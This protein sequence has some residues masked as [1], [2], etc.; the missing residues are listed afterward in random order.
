M[1]QTIFLLA[2]LFSATC[3]AQNN[4]KFNLDF[5]MYKDSED[6]SEG[7]IKWGSYT[8]SIDED[9]IHSGSKSAKISS[10]D[11]G[12]DF[13]SI[14][15]KIPAKYQ[16]EVI[17][18]EGYMKTKDVADGFAG[19]LMRI[20]GDG[21]SLAF[22]N[23]ES[24]EIKGTKDWKK[25]SIILPF[26]DEA[27]N[28]FVAGILVGKGEAWFDDFVLSIDGQDVQTLKEVKPELVKAQLDKEFDNGSLIDLP[29]LNPQL[30]NDLELLGKVW[31]FLKYHHPEI[32]AGNYNWDYEL[33]RLLPDYLKANDIKSRDQI[34]I[35]WIDQFG[36]IK[37]CDGCKEVDENAILKTD[38]SWFDDQGSLLRNKLQEVYAGRNT[39]K[40]YYIRMTP[41]VGNPVFQNEQDYAS[42]SYPDD[43][44]RLLTV[45]RYWNMIQYYFPNKHL[46]DKDWNTILKEYIPLFVEAK[47]ELAYERAAVQIIGEVAD[48]HANLWGGG[49]KIRE[50]RGDHYPAVHLRFIE[51]QLTVVDY[52]NPEL[53]EK[54]GLE[55]GDVITSV[56]GKSVVDLIDEKTPFYP[57]SNIPSR[58]RNLAPDLLRSTKN[59]I[60]IKFIRDDQ[61]LVKSIPLYLREDL[62]MYRWYPKK[63]GKCYKMLDD[64]IGY[65]TL[66]NIKNGDVAAIIK[67]FKDTKGIVIDIRNYPSTFVPF[68]LGSFFLSTAT[69]FAKFTEGSISNPGEFVM[70]PGSIISPAE[71]VYSGKLVILVNEL[72][73]SQA[74]YTAMAFRAGD[75]TTVIGSTTAGAD[76]NIS[77]ILLPGGLRTIISGIGVY[78]PNGGETQRIGIVPDIEVKPTLKGIKEGRDE[79]LERAQ[80]FI[81]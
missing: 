77:K 72:T 64:N 38:L 43:G 20:D 30:V 22:D 52:Y 35:N 65:V 49:D 17:T 6:L 47:D 33:F 10:D 81:K 36:I 4:P 24:Q 32:A 40:H 18:L 56:E 27:E 26:P 69:P 66:Q 60:E 61:E 75:N 41:N 9:V 54:I 7:W 44:F 37:P 8:L 57:A 55:I 76:G 62:N 11:I 21:G 73:Q 59:Q 5:E 50:E 80:A 71:D 19:L 25:Y 51:D 79:L 31:G 23:M 46:T 42:M 34:L 29:E 39:G 2:L 63:E 3:N 12:S 68:S 78:Y 15:Y 53:K 45:Y 67:E 74:E 1:K 14:A 70:R 58:L 28:I 13:G 16:G 48:T